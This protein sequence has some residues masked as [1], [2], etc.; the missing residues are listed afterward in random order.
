M[1][2]R[3]RLG[4]LPLRLGALP[5]RLGALPLRLGAL[6]PVLAALA[7]GCPAPE[8]DERAREAILEGEKLYSQFDEELVIRHFFADRRDGFFVDVGSW[9]PI[10]GSTTYY[11]EKHLGWSGF[12]IDAN[13]GLAPGY[14]KSRPRTRFFGYIITDHSGTLETLYLAGAV[15]S[16]KA[17]H[18]D[19]VQAAIAPDN[20]WAQGLAEAKRQVRPVPVPTMTLTELLDREGIASIDFLSMD[21]EQGEPAALAGF[22]IERF[23]PELVCIEAFPTVREAIRSYFEAHAYERLERYEAFETGSWY[24]APRER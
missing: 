1:P 13:T 15:S 7:L 18:I 14:A 3:R 4:A 5:L 20:P 2:P 22:D 9:K 23:R 6:P 17:G 8:L 10:E 24:F 16:T 11:L 21:I 12:A 19:D